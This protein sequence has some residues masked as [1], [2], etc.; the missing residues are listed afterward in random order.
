MAHSEYK[1]IGKKGQAKFRLYYDGPKKA[2]GSRNQ[3]KETFSI[4]PLPEKAAVIIKA[5][6][7][8]KNGT[9]TK[10]ESLLLERFE[11][12]ANELADLEAR[13]KEQQINDPTYIKPIEPVIVKGEIFTE[14]SARWYEYRAGTSRKGKRQPKTMWRYKQLLERLDA[15]FVDD[16]V[17]SINID[18]VE[19]CYAWLTV[20]PKKPGN[21]RK[22]P[23]KEADTLSAQTIWHYHRCLYSILEYAVERKLLENN[24]CKYVRPPELPPSQD[25]EQPDAYSEE[26]A[27]E[28]KSFMQNE[29][30]KYRAFINISLEI[31]PRPEETLALHWTD[32]DFKTQ[33]VDFNKTWQYLPGKGSFEKKYL[34][35]KSSKR[36][37]RLSAST[38]F[39]LKQLKGQQDAEKKRLGSKWIDSGAVFVSWNGKQVGGEWASQWWRKWIRKTNLPV[40]TLYSLRHTCVS[41]LVNAGAN[42]LEIARMVGHVN[43]EMI[44]KVYGHS[45]QKENFNGADI[46]ENIMNKKSST[47]KVE[48]KVEQ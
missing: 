23:L 8:R 15:F 35:N 46:M 31:G 12:Q 14:L 36:R 13:K 37:V 17:K 27:A 5:A 3:Q 26:Q 48:Q 10:T 44:W 39:I 32:I 47:K 18:R 7:N 30:L 22:T 11:K 33:I 43:T 40:K 6:E 38:I 25:D 16:E 9:V 4:S 28:I 42:P 19:E 24:P 45:I 1:G 34:K 29:E 20:Q 21:R 2:D 41:L